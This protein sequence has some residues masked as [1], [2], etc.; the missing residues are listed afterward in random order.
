MV[1]YNFSCLESHCE[2]PSS[3]RFEDNQDMHPRDILE[4]DYLLIFCPYTRIL[5]ILIF[6]RLSCM[7]LPVNIFLCDIVVVCNFWIFVIFA[8]VGR[9][10]RRCTRWTSGGDKIAS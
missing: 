1:Q 3:D 7:V 4:D 10:D 6:I 9:S 5:V 8:G 2:K